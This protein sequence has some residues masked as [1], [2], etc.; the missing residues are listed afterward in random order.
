MNVSFTPKTDGSASGTLTFMS[1]ASDS[2]AL[3][4]L[5]GIG[6]SPQYHRQPVV[7]CEQSSGGRL[8]RLSQ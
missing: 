8:Q 2:K 3:E 5:S 6:T 1:D 4:G 7:E